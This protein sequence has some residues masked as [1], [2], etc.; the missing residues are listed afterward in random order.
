[1]W[2]ERVSQRGK[3]VSI[4]ILALVTAAPLVPELDA[5]ENATSLNSQQRTGDEEKR[6]D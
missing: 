5:M 3:G 1:M 4:F 6:C 2:R